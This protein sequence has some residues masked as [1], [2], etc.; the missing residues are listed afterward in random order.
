MGEGWKAEGN[1]TQG[2]LTSVPGRSAKLSPLDSLMGN[3]IKK[4]ITC[5]ASRATGMEETQETF[6]LRKIVGKKT[7]RK[8]S[9]RGKTNKENETKMCI[10][11]RTGGGNRKERKAILKGKN[12]SMK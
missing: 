3:N 12:L 6:I 10:E 7:N 8:I 4:R 5:G 9:Y 1:P 2:E 11:S